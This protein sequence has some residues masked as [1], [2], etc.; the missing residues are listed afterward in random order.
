M[1]QEEIQI[2]AFE[3]NLKESIK[4]I[5][6]SDLGVISRAVGIANDV[7]SPGTENTL[8]IIAEDDFKKIFVRAFTEWAKSNH[9]K[10]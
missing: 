3:K 5:L 2:K 8:D 1:T 10:V 6:D 7:S 9:D 4:R